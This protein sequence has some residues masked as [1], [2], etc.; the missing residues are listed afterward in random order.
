MP[1]V[2]R[3]DQQEGAAEHVRLYKPVDLARDVDVWTRVIDAAADGD[4][5][6][7]G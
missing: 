5:V 7:R 3:S 2:L 6:R 1:T 4:G